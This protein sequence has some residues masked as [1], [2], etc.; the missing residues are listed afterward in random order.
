[1]RDSFTATAFSSWRQACG[2]SVEEAAALLGKSKLMIQLLD[3]GTTYDGRPC[4]PQL[5]TRRLMTAA[6]QRINLDPWPV[7]EMALK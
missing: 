4:K 6:Y 2:L 1:M 5:D 7:E 3:R